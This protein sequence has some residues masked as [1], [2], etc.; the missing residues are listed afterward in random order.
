MNGK[1]LCKSQGEGKSLT[2]LVPVEITSIGKSD[3]VNITKVI[4]S[5]G[6]YLAC[7]LLDKGKEKELNSPD[8]PMFYSVFANSS[9]EES[10]CMPCM[11]T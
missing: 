1:I 4:N 11:C 3:N 5:S 6:R 9:Y 10:N 7:S 2:S 8:F